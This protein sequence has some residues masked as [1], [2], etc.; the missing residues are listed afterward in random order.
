MREDG[1]DLEPWEQQPSE[2]PLYY[3][4]FELYCHLGWERSVRLAVEKWYA[5]TG[6]RP[7][8]NNGRFHNA[9]TKWRWAERARRYWLKEQRRNEKVLEAQRLAI[10]ARHAGLSERWLKKLEDGFNKVKVDTTM[11]GAVDAQGKVL[12][13]QRVAYGDTD[14]ERRRKGRP[15]GDEDDALPTVEDRLKAPEGNDHGDDPDN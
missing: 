6:H 11:R 7:A 1:L 5:E 8:K 3:H 2:P 12:E 15:R 14:E 4:V 10:Y 13:I 9:A